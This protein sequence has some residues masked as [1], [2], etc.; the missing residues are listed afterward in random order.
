V[1][2]ETVHHGLVFSRSHVSAQQR[3]RGDCLHQRRQHVSVIQR[4]AE[5]VVSLLCRLCMRVQ[6]PRGVGAHV[7]RPVAQVPGDAASNARSE[8]AP[9]RR[10]RQHT[11]RKPSELREKRFISSALRHVY[12][13]SHQHA[14]AQAAG[15]CLAA[16][17]GRTVSITRCV[18]ACGSHLSGFTAGMP[19]KSDVLAR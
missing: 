5:L 10:R 14:H 8:R 18:S 12:R 15:A 4:S 9:L 19:S 11:Q 1:L 17:R 6:Q 16:A 2:L 7:R 3:A 13:H